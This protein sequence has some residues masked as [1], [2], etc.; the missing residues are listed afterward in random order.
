M[1][2]YFYLYF[3]KVRHILEGYVKMK[4]KKKRERNKLL[5]HLYR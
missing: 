4:K 3:A 5:M 2:K 1:L